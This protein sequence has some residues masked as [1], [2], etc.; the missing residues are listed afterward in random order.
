MDS[1]GDAPLFM[2]KGFAWMKN[3]CFLCS[4][5]FVRVKSQCTWSAAAMVLRDAVTFGRTLNSV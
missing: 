3:V 2:Q 5:S 4:L 1:A